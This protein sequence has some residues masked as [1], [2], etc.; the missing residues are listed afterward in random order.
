MTLSTNQVKKLVTEIA[1]AVN[2]TLDGNS[3]GLIVARAGEWKELL[4]WAT[5]TECP[6]C[7]YEDIP[8]TGNCESCGSN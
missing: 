4:E 1:I 2:E 3:D 7:G 6:Y 8:H 5:L